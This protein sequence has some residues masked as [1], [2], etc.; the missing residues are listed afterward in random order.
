MSGFFILMKVVGS[1]TQFPV[2]LMFAITCHKSQGLTLPAVVLHCSKEFVAGL[3]YVAMTRV[4]SCENIQVL[5]F[6]P[7][8]LLP[9]PEEAINVCVSHLPPVEDCSC[10]RKKELK[11]Q[12]FL[13]EAD[14][15]NVQNSKSVE[16]ADE[17]SKATENVIKSYFERGDPDESVIDLETVYFFLSEEIQSEFVKTPPPEFDVEALLRAMKVTEPLSDVANDKNREIESL[18]T[19]NGDTKLFAQLLWCRGCAI[20]LEE[21][22]CNFQEL[23]ISTKQ[24][25]VD[26]RQF[27]LLVTRCP[28][29]F[30]DLKL[31]FKSEQPTKVQR[32]IGA[33]LMVEIF[34][35]IVSTVVRLTNERDAADPVYLNVREMPAEGLAK[36]RY[37]GAWAI[38]KVLDHEMKYVRDNIMSAV[39]R[40]Q[41]LVETSYARCSLLEE[42]VVANF[43]VLEKNSKY[44]ES[45]T[46]TEDRQY[47][48]RGLLH[49]EDA[50]FE[51]FIEA[52]SLRVKHLNESKMERIKE[53]VV[54]NAL[55]ALNDDKGLQTKW[56]MCFP[57]SV[58][59][60][61]KVMF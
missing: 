31:L 15:A 12:D 34:K 23:Q 48:S 24:W 19:L 4:R 57:A 9:P 25:A 6:H 42:F 61:N 39:S 7:S 38:K 45:L 40:T 58:K 43:S 41:Q 28:N 54:D 22:L 2:A 11:E 33:Q 10:C 55:A 56:E 51:F 3:T 27:F 44:P 35:I 37:V 29:F 14:T 26:T 49:I 16:S 46:V 32:L 8:K 50:V 20:I 60:E 1:R 21:S 17:I 5:G 13:L 18:L 59:E 30:R 47:R 36:L 53:G 52:E